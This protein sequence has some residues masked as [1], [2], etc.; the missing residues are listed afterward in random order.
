MLNETSSAPEPG[1]TAQTPRWSAGELRL[2]VLGGHHAGS[3][4]ALSAAGD[5][6]IGSGE[7]AD[8]ILMDAGL[9]ESHV[10]MTCTPSS[11]G[12]AAGD[13]IVALGT[14]MDAR[15]LTTGERG[16][17]SLPARFALVTE[18]GWQIEIGVE[19]V[20]TD[21]A[22]TPA[23]ATRRRRSWTQWGG[24]GLA[25]VLALLVL[26]N[27]SLSSLAT[28]GDQTLIAPDRVALAV[29]TT[30]PATPV[31]LDKPAQPTGPD[32]AIDALRAKLESVDLQGLRIEGL[33]GVIA[34]RGKI[35]PDEMLKWRP[36]SRWYDARFGS[37]VPISA[38]ITVA[39]KLFEPPQKPLGLWLGDNPHI[40]DSE[41][42]RKKVGQKTSDGWEILSISA[43]ELVLKRGER[44]IAI[45]F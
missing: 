15:T 23:G 2:T 41:G 3:A 13:G 37:K 30:Q 32:A 24:V 16:S 35:T 27:Q 11:I 42:L 8:I 38:E 40:I 12:L 17:L 34:V 25:S 18:S 1:P 19:A 44:Q 28:D 4:L 45:G 14:G 29:T 10:T 9:G 33:G 31:V 43:A 26:S 5:A 7:D 20:E 36:I 39:D 21:A 6:V 22:A